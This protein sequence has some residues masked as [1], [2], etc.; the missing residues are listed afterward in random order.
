M[1][2]HP[3]RLTLRMREGRSPSNNWTVIECNIFM[4]NFTGYTGTVL[5]VSCLLDYMEE[6]W[7][8]SFQ[9]V[10]KKMTQKC[11]DLYHKKKELRN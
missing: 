5:H 8:G 2:T 4:V 6:K 11:T 10:L 1:G 9:K 3:E 7:P